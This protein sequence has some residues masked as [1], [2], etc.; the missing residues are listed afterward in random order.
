MRLHYVVSEASK[1]KYVHLYYNQHSLFILVLLLNRKK[2][3]LAL[4]FIRCMFESLTIIL[5]HIWVNYTLILYYWT[6]PYMFELSMRCEPSSFN[7]L[8]IHIWEA[9]WSQKNYNE[10]I[11]DPIILL[12]III[13][14]L[15]CCRQSDIT[16]P[17]TER[18]LAM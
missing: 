14:G 16:L 10:T 6:T 12:C 8:S 3:T 7:S 1:F 15:R 17:A 9:I 11:V 4:N 13:H 18:D 2:I 5:L